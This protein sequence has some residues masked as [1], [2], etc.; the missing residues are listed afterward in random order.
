VI[1]DAR[2]SLAGEV[3]RLPAGRYALTAYLRG[4]GHD[5]C[6][7][8]IGEREDICSV[9]VKLKERHAYTLAVSQERSRCDFAE[10]I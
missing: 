1:M 9:D 8:L 7:Q 4:C 2:Q 5:A 10:V 6:I 3:M